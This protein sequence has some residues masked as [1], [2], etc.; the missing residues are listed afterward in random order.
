MDFHGFGNQKDDGEVVVDV[1]DS[2]EKYV[3]VKYN[4]DPVLYLL[5][6][7][8]RE[9]WVISRDRIRAIFQ[10]RNVTMRNYGHSGTPA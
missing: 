7:R 8:I 4:L 6:S 3:K 9:H 2:A 1:A 10:L 5:R